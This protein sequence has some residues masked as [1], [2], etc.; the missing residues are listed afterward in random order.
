MNELPQLIIIIV[1]LL[2][3]YGG[4]RVW[5]SRRPSENADG[6][7]GGGVGQSATDQHL[8]DVIVHDHS[9]IP[10]ADRNKSRFNLTGKDAEV[11]AKVLKR[12]LSQDK[13]SGE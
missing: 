10:R 8:A 13:E 1:V 5:T 6:S 12:M 9:D 11:A 2:V 4:I 3:A 7:P